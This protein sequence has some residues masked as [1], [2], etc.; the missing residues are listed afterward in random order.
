MLNIVGWKGGV[1]R[2]DMAMGLC[3]NKKMEDLQKSYKLDGPLKGLGKM[4]WFLEMD[5][6]DF[7][8]SQLLIAAFTLSASIN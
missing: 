7:I 8:I 2:P 5:V 1:G 6:L 4:N 3:V